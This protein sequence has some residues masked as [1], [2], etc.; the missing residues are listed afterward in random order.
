MTKIYI[1]LN[2]ESSK[3]F[4]KFNSKE[5]TEFNKFMNKYAEQY[6]SPKLAERKK[7]E[8]IVEA[9]MRSPLWKKQ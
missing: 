6:L 9:I 3:I 1:Q 2:E 7:A 5:R 4:L 8:K